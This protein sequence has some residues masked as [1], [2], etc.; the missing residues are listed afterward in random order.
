MLVHRAP[1]LS[2]SLQTLASD[3]EALDAALEVLGREALIQFSPDRFT[4]TVN[5]QAQ[6]AMKAALSEEQQRQWAICAVR[7]VNHVFPVVDFG[8]W[9]LCQHYLPQARICAEYITT[10]HMTFR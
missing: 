2:A 6:E 1:E 9:S 8:T 7:L 10:F 5:Q 4:L 3:P